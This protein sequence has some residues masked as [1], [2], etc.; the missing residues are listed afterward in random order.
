[1]TIP[2]KSRQAGG[3]DRPF[4]F[5]AYHVV[6]YQ[7]ADA[8]IAAGEL[9]VQHSPP[10]MLPHRLDWLKA[11]ASNRTWWLAVRDL[12]QRPVASFGVSWF[13][14]RA[15]PGHRLLRLE[16]LRFAPDPGPAE[17]AVQY[18]VNVARQDGRT[19][20]LTVEPFFADPVERDRGRAVLEEAGLR[21]AYGTR[22]YANT[23]RI[24]LTP[25]PEEILSRFHPTARRHI[26]AVT[27]RQ[28]EIR[29][30][31]DSAI[32]ARL[33]EIS[34]ETFARTD[35]SAEQE[36]WPALIAYCRAHPSLAR[37]VSLVRTDQLGPKAVVAFALGVNHGDHVEYAAAGSTRPPDLRMP[38]GYALAWDL[39]C[40]AR[41]VGARWF[42]FGGIGAASAEDDERRGIHGF[43][44]MFGSDVVEVR[45]EWSFEARPMRGV[46]VRAAARLAAR[47]RD[48]KRPRSHRGRRG[49]EAPR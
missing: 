20:N 35:A 32:A 8:A 29:L 26:R 44:K 23:V 49:P 34:T 22:M 2:A 18:L 40:W 6:A 42:D 12:E 48:F 15:L 45:Q 46:W 24:D 5:G 14:T 27:K 10:G 41:T 3:A 39:I 9:E 21:L 1:M 47:V 38:F 13:P 11:T 7:S 25:Q 36:P 33:D 16:R 4:R 30:I 37:L 19:V 28:V 31:Q 43:K 17:A